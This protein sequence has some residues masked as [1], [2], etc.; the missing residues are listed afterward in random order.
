MLWTATSDLIDF[1]PETERP[2][3]HST[4]PAMLT[5]KQFYQEEISELIYEKQAFNIFIDGSR[6]ADPT[7]KY[8]KQCLKGFMT[9][10]KEIPK[11]PCHSFWRI[12]F[13]L[14]PN[15]ASPGSAS[16]RACEGSS[17]VE[18]NKLYMSVV[19]MGFS[20][21]CTK[22]APHWKRPFLKGPTKVE[23]LCYEADGTLAT[24]ATPGNDSV[25]DNSH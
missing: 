13:Q 6:S 7:H 25:K 19:L 8:S 21:F 10:D 15:V 4:L 16:A 24:S 2:Q 1:Y 11:Y 23:V 9:P 14:M 3:G 17:A 12:R 5:S 18:E 20:L 22:L